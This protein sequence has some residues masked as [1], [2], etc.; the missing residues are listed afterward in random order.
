MVISRIRALSLS[1]PCRFGNLA[2][3]PL[4]TYASTCSPLESLDSETYGL[5]DPNDVSLKTRLVLYLSQVAGLPGQPQPLASLL[6]T[7]PR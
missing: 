6:R 3:D 5:V 4:A 1:G 2:F 7:S